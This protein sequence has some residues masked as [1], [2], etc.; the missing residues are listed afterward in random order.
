MKTLLIGFGYR[1]RAGKDTI[2]M[3]VH[4][5]MPAETVIYRFSGDL[6]A[7]ARVLGMRGKDSPLLQALGTD[8]IRRVDPSRWVRCLDAQ[9]Q[10]DQPV[11]AL[12]P[13]V[14]FKNELDY[15]HDNGGVSFCVRRFSM[16]G[17]EYVSDD[18]DPNHPSEIELSPG[19]FTYELQ[20]VSGDTKALRANAQLVAYRIADELNR[21]WAKGARVDVVA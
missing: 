20:A 17:E 6:K 3:Q 4:R 13:D 14:R 12:V 16:E 19:D 9:I 5:M 21:R 2:A 10:E 1:A 8:V 18:R 15:I 11:V 7:F